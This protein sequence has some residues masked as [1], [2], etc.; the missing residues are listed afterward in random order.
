MFLSSIK[1]WLPRKPPDRP[2]D[3]PLTRFQEN[4]QYNINLAS[5]IERYSKISASAHSY[6]ICL[7]NHRSSPSFHFFRDAT[8]F[9][10]LFCKIPRKKKPCPIAI[11]AFDPSDDAVIVRQIQGGYTNL[12]FS[13]YRKY[14]ID[15]LQ[16]LRWERLLIHIVFDWAHANKF[17]SVGVI[18]AQAS[19]WYNSELLHGDSLT[20]HQR[21]MEMRYNVTAQRMGFRFDPVQNLYIRSCADPL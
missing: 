5:Y 4:P 9:F 2:Q 6:L 7:G 11:L 14:L 10:V 3:Y 15:S 19:S 1:R 20:A 12:S 8:Y 17:K 18:R 16:I 13:G 21:R